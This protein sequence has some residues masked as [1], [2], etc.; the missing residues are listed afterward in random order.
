MKIIIAAAALAIGCGAPAAAVAQK[1]QPDRAEAS[2]GRSDIV[3]VSS[4]DAEMNRAKAEA[5]AGLPAFMAHLARPGAGEEGFSVKFDL[6]RTGEFIWASELS[7]ENGRLSGALANEPVDSR[8]RLGQR[9]IIPEAD[10][11]DWTY[12]RSG[13]AEGHFTTRILLPRLE[14]A[15]A[16]E[17]RAA[18]GW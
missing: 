2:E 10:I 13:R 17:V 16:A 3:Q 15:Q 8:Y 6:G 11:I 9:V 1:S 4:E 5:R 18:L 7:R 12:R 14:P